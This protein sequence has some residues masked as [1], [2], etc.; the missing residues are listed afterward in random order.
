VN[1]KIIGAM[2]QLLKNYVAWRR[3]NSTSN[4]ECAITMHYTPPHRR[5]KP[6]IWSQGQKRHTCVPN[7]DHPHTLLTSNKH[8]TKNAATPQP[9]G[10]L[11][12]AK[13]RRKPSQTNTQMQKPKTGF[14]CRYKPSNHQKH[15]VQD[16]PAIMRSRTIKRRHGATA[17]GP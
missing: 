10:T 17:Q 14:S 5:R 3:R 9:T 2:R 11:P 13:T 7:T 4:K 8:H 6:T 12:P 1:R 16:D 15:R